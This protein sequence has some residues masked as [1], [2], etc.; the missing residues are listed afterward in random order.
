MINKILTSCLIALFVFSSGGNLKKRKTTKQLY[1]SEPACTKARKSDAN[2]SCSVVDFQIDKLLKDADTNKTLFFLVAEVPTQSVNIMPVASGPTTFPTSWGARGVSREPQ[3]IAGTIPADIQD[4]IVIITNTRIGFSSTTAKRVSKITAGMT[5]YAVPLLARNALLGGRTVIYQAITGG[6]P[7]TG[8]WD[9]VVVHFTDGTQQPVGGPG[10]QRRLAYSDLPSGGG[11]ATS[12]GASQT[13]SF[14]IPTLSDTT[15]T[16]ETANRPVFHN[17]ASLTGAGIANQ[18]TQ[19]AVSNV[20]RIT[21][22]NAG[23]VNIVWEDEVRIVTSTA[24]GSGSTGELIWAMT[25][26]DK[27]DN[28]LRSWVGEHAIEDPITSAINFPFSMPTGITPVMAGDYFTLNFAFNSSVSNR[29][30]VFALPADN[31]GLD[32]RVEVVYFPLTTINTGPA[33]PRGPPGPA[34][35]KGDKGDPGEGGDSDLLA[36]DNTPT[37]LTPYKHG[38]I[39]PIN[40]PATGKWL[41][42][43]GADAGELHS[44]QMTSGAD[45]NNKSSGFIIGDTLNYGYS[46]FGDVFGEL[47]TADGGQP[48]SASNTPIMRIELEGDVFRV[49]STGVE[50]GL[51][52]DLTV[53][54]RKTDLQ[55]APANIWIRFYSGVPGADNQLDTI[56]L[57]RGT[58]NPAHIYHTYTEASGEDPSGAGENRSTI[59]YVNFFTSNPATGDQTSNPL[60]VHQ[61]KTTR[62]FDPP[63]PVETGATIVT[64][65][66]GLSGASRLPA[67]AVKDLPSAGEMIPEYFNDV[68]GSKTVSV[69]ASDIITRLSVTGSISARYNVGMVGNDTS[70]II[71]GG[72]ETNDFY[73]YEVSGNAITVTRL[74]VTGSISA[75]Y[76][77]GMVGNDT[78][79]IIFGGYYYDGNT[80]HDNYYNDFYKYEVSGNAITVTRLSVTGSIPARDSMG[81]VGN[82]TSGIIFGG[83]YYDTDNDDDTYYNDFYKYEV[84]GNAITVT[85]LSLTGSIPA[86]YNMGMVGNNTSGIIFGGTTSN[87]RTNDF[88][89]YEVSGNAITV[90][91]LSV[92]GFAPFLSRMGMVGNDTSGIIFGGFGVLSTNNAGSSIFLNNFYK[93]EVSGNTVTVTNLTFTG[94]ISARYGM[95]MVG[96]NTSGIIFG[97]V[98][99]GNRATND[100]YKY[101]RVPASESQEGILLK[102]PKTPRRVTS[103]P[104]ESTAKE[105]ETVWVEADYTIDNGV[106]ITPQSFA[107]T[108]LD[109]VFDSDAPA[110][111]GSRG[112]YAKQDAGF[113]FGEVH[114][115]LPDN[116]V[117]ISDTRIYVKR[118]TLTNLS[119]LHLGDTEYTLTRVAQSAGSKLN[120]N[121]AYAST[122]PDVDYY[123]ITG[124]LPA[125]DWDNLRFETTTAG[126]FIPA[127]STITKGFYEFKNNDW[128]RASYNAP[129]AQPD[130]DIIWRVEERRPGTRSDKNLAFVASGSTFTISDPFPG[131]L[132]I[133]YNNLS[134]D[135]DTY[136]RFTVFVPLAGF[137]DSRAPAVLKIGSVNYSLSYFETDAGQAVYRSPLIKTSERISS[138]S[139]VNG[140][141]V[142]LLDGSWVGQSGDTSVYRTVNKGTIQGV[143]NSATGVHVP[144][145]NPHEG[146]RIEMLNDYTLHGGA[147]LTAKESS[148]SDSRGTSITG[149]FTGYEKDSRYDNGSTGG[150]LGSLDPVNTSFDGLISFS[151]ARAAGSEANKTM[152][153]SNNGNTYT[154]RFVYINGI[155]YTVGSAVNRD[156]Y[157]LT[158]LDG[159]FLKNGKQYYVNAETSAGARL[160]PDVVLKQGSFYIWNGL[161]WQLEKA[162]LGQAEV[163]A[164]INNRVQSWARNPA[165]GVIR[166]GSICGKKANGD[167]KILTSAEFTA[168]QTKPTGTFFCVRVQ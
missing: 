67:T 93:Y 5:E 130:K 157:P 127:S 128:G 120:S 31:P 87:R 27:D 94:S 73:K 109:S 149:L 161:Y 91:R 3:A 47:K 4:D 86:R 58:D 129:P 6:L 32:E 28:D 147:V 22:T 92:T 150:D 71:F 138:A 66:S 14:Q 83:N 49:P 21:I 112:W 2:A 33:G 144:P 118:N 55:T 61:A 106:N 75:R 9:N 96:N 121:P 10:V 51:N 88:Y 152:F 103:L 145:T 13:T 72:T 40:N 45:A 111:I 89:K 166:V 137:E 142:Q 151:N 131:I 158:G 11:G 116:F 26:Y 17:I 85:R 146:T 20:A 36:L 41:E 62:D 69:S 48:L 132:R 159:S 126:T 44:F 54:I 79:G 39:L 163:D 25:H 30:V 8:D 90:T 60:E 160:Y 136:Q 167:D 134:T 52:W 162:G 77:M 29:N 110:N 80:D 1:L 135:T 122:L 63:T 81:M 102:V 53:L 56:R 78:S 155:K 50:L 84:S 123:T 68:I 124:G 154:P 141:N 125:G 35:E 113:Q 18:I 156:F 64:K 57:A 34:G 23:Y 105:G 97:G 143:A 16:V 7:S 76:N 82:D 15:L 164:R 168:L 148:G 165:T 46:S 101:L 95:G 24:G 117:L 133:T 19:S 139:T 70:G 114:P 38:Q 108:E 99:V 140:M 98:G 107:G 37:D 65:L 104:A 12:L 43:T 59:Q 42:V 115:A 153:V 100:F 74:S 119:K